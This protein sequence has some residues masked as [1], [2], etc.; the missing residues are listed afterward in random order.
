MSCSHCWLEAIQRLFVKT[1]AKA[2]VFRFRANT[3]APTG[4]NLQERHLV[5]NAVINPSYDRLSADNAPPLQNRDY[6]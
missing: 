1:A 2:A 3:G 6:R 5:I 4:L